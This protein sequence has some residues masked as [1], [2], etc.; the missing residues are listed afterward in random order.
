MKI[1][2]IGEIGVDIFIYCNSNRL[3]P[4]APVPILNPFKTVINAGMAGNTGENLDVLSPNSTIQYLSQDENITKTR[5]VDQKSNHMFF[6]NVSL[7]LLNRLLNRSSPSTGCTFAARSI[8]D[9]STDFSLP[10]FV[11]FLLFSPR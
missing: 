6:R 1:V 2:V 5:Y 4:E 9:E 10:L 7:H 3:S 11:I 8:T